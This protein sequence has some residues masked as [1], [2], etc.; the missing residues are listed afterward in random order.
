MSRIET[1]ILKT[2]LGFLIPVT[3]FFA[4]WH[5]SA[6]L[7]IFHILP[8]QEW[9]IILASFSGLG[10]GIVLDVLFLRRWV[11]SIYRVPLAGMAVALVYYM[12]VSFALF[13]GVP[14]LHTLFGIP[15]GL[16]IGR[17]LRAQ[18]AEED[19]SRKLAQSACRFTAILMTL[20]CCLSAFI[21]LWDRYTVSNLNGMFRDMLGIP[22][23]F[24]PGRIGAL[25]LIGGSALVALEYWLTRISIAWAY[26]QP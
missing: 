4:A 1:L 12:L 9:M 6:S 8:L 16:Y 15:V 17:R 5:V 2:T 20:I 19:Q 23:V 26:R 13:M 18:N 7:Y 22:I 14:V 21:A 3:L 10:S 25:I 11:D 24:T